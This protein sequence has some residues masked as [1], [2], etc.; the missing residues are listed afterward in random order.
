MVPD[1]ASVSRD[2]PLVPAVIQHQPTCVA[3]LLSNRL[4]HGSDGMI[5]AST[6]GCGA[7]EGGPG[8][9]R[10]RRERR[11]AGP[12][13]WDGGGGPQAPVDGTGAEVR[14]PQSM[15]RERRSA[16]PSR[17]DGSGGPQAPVDGTGAKA[18]GPAAAVNAVGKT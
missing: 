9:Q 2:S 15:G 12:S 18:A 3:Q 10:T 1:C 7:A 4:P 17:W 14:R 5:T 13:R 6:D 11:S 8:L 16:G